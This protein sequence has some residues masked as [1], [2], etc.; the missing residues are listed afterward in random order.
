MTKG[1]LDN[2]VAGIFLLIFSMIVIIAWFISSQINAAF[3]TAGISTVGTAGA[4]AAIGVWDW[5]FILL[6]VF[7]G[8]TDIIGAFMARSHPVFFI[9]SLIFTLILGSACANDVQRLRLIRYR[10]GRR[11]GCGVLKYGLHNAKSE[12]LL[13]HAVNHNVSRDV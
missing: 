2:I 7:M 9:I 6:F 8:I 3:V 5:G 12:F 1:T 10:G 13:N 4:T 11:G